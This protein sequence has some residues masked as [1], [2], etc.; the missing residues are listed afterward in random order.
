MQRHLGKF[1]LQLL[2]KQGGSH[3]VVK[4]LGICESTVSRELCAL[5][6]CVV[7]VAHCTAVNL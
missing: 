1:C 5:Y 7:S 4:K 6:S 3:D 2:D